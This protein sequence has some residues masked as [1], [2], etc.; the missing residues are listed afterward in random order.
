MRANC[1]CVYISDAESEVK[2][3]R[4]PLGPQFCQG[5]SIP[6]ARMKLIAPLVRW[7]GISSINQLG[8]CTSDVRSMHLT[9]SVLRD[10]IKMLQLC[11]WFIPEH[12]EKVKE[13]LARADLGCSVSSKMQINYLNNVRHRLHVCK[14]IDSVSHLLKMIGPTEEI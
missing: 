9:H 7:L 2:I 4:F 11:I 12:R 10:H 5:S 13:K 3:K 14:E 1:E 8:P 6:R